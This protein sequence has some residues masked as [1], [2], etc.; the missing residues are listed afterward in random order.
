[1]KREKEGGGKNVE[2]TFQ[3]LLE[4]LRCP[5]DIGL[6]LLFFLVDAVVDLE[7][8]FELRSLILN[9]SCLSE[10]KLSILCRFRM[11]ALVRLDLVDF[12]EKISGEH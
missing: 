10:Y 7:K 3:A 11:V 12:L 2:G 6:D 9:R 5:I 8:R 4:L 1:M